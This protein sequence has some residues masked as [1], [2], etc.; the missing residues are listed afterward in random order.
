VSV[1]QNYSKLPI[2][3]VKVPIID[4]QR[5]ETLIAKRGPTT[6]LFRGSLNSFFFWS[7]GPIKMACSKFLNK[8]KK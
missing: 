5:Q 6:L 4:N 2:M 3:L 8:I 1:A 7:D